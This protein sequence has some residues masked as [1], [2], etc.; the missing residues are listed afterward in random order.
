MID[1][2]LKF[3]KRWESEKRDVRVGKLEEAVWLLKQY[4]KLPQFC[5]RLAIKLCVC[6]LHGYLR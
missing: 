3:R 4:V 5:T 1:E 2:E 6:F